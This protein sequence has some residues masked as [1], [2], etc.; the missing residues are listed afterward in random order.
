MQSNP[1]HV[2]DAKLSAKDY[3]AMI[4]TNHQ[5]EDFDAF[6]VDLMGTSMSR[7]RENHD[8]NPK[9]IDLFTIAGKKT[10]IMMRVMW[11]N[12]SLLVN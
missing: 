6:F 2:D 11:S 7:V 12:I 4:S 9:S 1:F 10:M 5:D 8:I 3:G